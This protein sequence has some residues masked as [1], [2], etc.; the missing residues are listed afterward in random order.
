MES[1]PQHPV[2]G[3][4]FPGPELEPPPADFADLDLIASRGT[5]PGKG[6]RAQTLRLQRSS[7]VGSMRDNVNKDSRLMICV[8]MGIFHF[9]AHFSTEN[10]NL[11]LRPWLRLAIFG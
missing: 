1:L 8:V 2:Q 3:L 5:S 11:I 9:S 6:F 7:V 10:M 4:P